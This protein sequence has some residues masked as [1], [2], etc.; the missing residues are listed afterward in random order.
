MFDRFRE[1]RPRGSFWH[2]EPDVPDADLDPYYLGG[3]G[4]REYAPPAPPPMVPGLQ[5][6]QTG[7]PVGQPSMDDWRWAYADT[8][9][10]SSRPPAC[11]T[12]DGSGWSGGQPCRACDGS[13]WTS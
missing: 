3:P 10:V 11:Y 9:E 7:E 6:W 13:G 4:H 8:A 1:L 12:C 2:P 5:P